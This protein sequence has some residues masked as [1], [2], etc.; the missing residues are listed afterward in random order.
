MLP[1]LRFWVRQVWFRKFDFGIKRPRRHNQ[2]RLDH[3]S[4]VAQLVERAAV[5]R[6]VVGSS[7]TRGANTS[8]GLDLMS[9]AP[10]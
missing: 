6:F 9:L 8:K 3:L 1:C 10:C 2:K 4:P 7:P 5:N